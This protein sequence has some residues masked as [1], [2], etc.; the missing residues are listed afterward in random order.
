[1]RIG[2]LSPVKQPGA[3]PM[4]VKRLGDLGFV[5]GKNLTVELRSSDG[6]VERFTPL[7]RELVQANCDLI[8]SYGSHQSARALMQAT[9]SIPI[10]ILAINYEPV[11]AGVVAS[12]RRPGGNVTGIYVPTLL[13]AAKRLQLLR[14][15]LPKAKRILFLGDVF[16]SNELEAT[17]AA[18]SRLDME[19]VAAKFVSQPYDIAAALERGR[20]AGV[21]ALVLP[22]SPVFYVER[23]RVERLVA[24]TRL[25][26]IVAAPAYIDIGFMSYGV[27]APQAFGRAAGIAASILKGANPG[28]I[29]VEQ[30]AV[31]EIV[32]N[33]KV[34][35]AIDLRIPQSVLLQATRV[36]E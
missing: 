1:V 11:A 22:A 10:V 27:D 34:A 4:I 36:I 2:V 35:R 9:A 29:A 3:L 5:E 18:A 28:E 24:R 13:L 32:V 12:L 14:E 7:A 15:V 33:L 31:Y 26:T 23:A 20:A 21:D 25:P 19:V 8:I 30:A 17:R 6:V 16:T